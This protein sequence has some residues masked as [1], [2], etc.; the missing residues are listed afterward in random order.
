MTT[1]QQGVDGKDLKAIED[2]IY[3]T[4]NHN[5]DWRKAEGAYQNI[6]AAHSRPAPSP[7]LIGSIRTNVFMD[8][9]KEWLIERVNAGMGEWEYV[10]SNIGEYYA[11]APSEE[12]ARS[13][14]EMAMHTCPV[15]TQQHDAAIVAQAR[16]RTLDEII[17]TL[18]DLNRYSCQEYE[19]ASLSDN[20]REMRI[21]LEYGNRLWGIIRSLRTE[22]P[23]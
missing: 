10:I 12:I 2:Y 16:N 6:L 19:E 4:M 14:V 11:T 1:Q 23:K 3:S 20:E 5:P 18:S 8:E 22:A 17:E 15:F 7:E 21:H 9:Q 13:I